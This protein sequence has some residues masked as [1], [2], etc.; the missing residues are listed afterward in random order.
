MKR[1]KK[2]AKNAAW[3]AFSLYVRTRDCIETTGFPDQGKCATCPNYYPVQE[4]QAGHF[5]DGRSNNVLFSE[6]GCHAQCYA[7]NVAKHGNKEEYW[8]FMEQ[9]YGREVIDELKAEKASPP[10]Q[11]TIED[12]DK[13]KEKYNELTKALHA[14]YG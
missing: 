6:R 3:K 14:R 10:I 13:I 7:C 1:T 4:L 12:Y 2:S 9:K 5:L 11:R 8:P